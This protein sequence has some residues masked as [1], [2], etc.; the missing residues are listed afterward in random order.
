[1]TILLTNLTIWDG[2]APSRADAILINGARIVA[3]GATDELQATIRIDC[4]GLTALPGLIDAHVHMELDPDQ[5]VPPTRTDTSAAARARMVDR[6]AAMLDAGITTA[7]DLGGGAWLEFELRDRIR[8]GEIRGPRLLCAG[9]PVTSPSG[10]CHFWGGEAA[11]AAEA[12][13]VIDRQV[14]HGADLIKVMATGGRLTRGTDPGAA[15]FDLTTLEAIVASAAGHGLAVAAHCHGTEGIRFAAAAGVATIEHCSW[16]GKAG[17]G[18]EYDA[19]AAATIAARGIRVSPTVNLGWGRHLEPRNVSSRTRLQ[20]N[21]AAM[22]AAGIRLIASTDAGI[23]GVRHHDLPRALPIFAV[24][25]GLDPE[26]TLA[27]ATS[28]AASALGLAG[29]TGRIAPGLAADLLLV[30]GDP[31]TDLAVLARPA[32]V[33]MQGRGGLF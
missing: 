16:A 30:S 9:Q 28:G 3:L 26:E 1:M 31:C 24:L 15:Q 7:R 19:A 11:S 6:A 12:G 14:S 13:I 29:E 22:R 32:G 20:G 8:S 27:T 5:H 21:F 10:H 25:A 4:A 23:P 18:A 2:E 33:W 17:W